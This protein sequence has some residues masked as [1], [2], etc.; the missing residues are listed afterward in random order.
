MVHWLG[1]LSRGTGFSSQNLHAVCNPSSSEFKASSGHCGQCTYVVHI[2]TCMY[3]H[4]I[5]I[6]KSLNLSNLECTAKFLR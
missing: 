2:Y 1:V 4:K 3:I 6:H 5:I